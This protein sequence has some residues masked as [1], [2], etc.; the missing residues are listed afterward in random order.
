VGDRSTEAATI[1]ASGTFEKLEPET[2]PDV[3]AE[4]GATAAEL[5]RTRRRRLAL[6]GV[7]VLP[8]V[9]LALGGL[10]YSSMN[11]EPLPA[12]Y[13]A[14]GKLADD[15]RPA[16]L[17]RTGDHT[18]FV[19]IPGGTF[20][21][22]NSGFD[23]TGSSSDDDQPAHPVSLSDY[24][25]Q[26]TEVTNGEM[27]AYFRHHE[28]PHSERPARFQAAWDQIRSVG[29]DPVKY[30]AVGI[31]HQLATEYAR[32]VGG[33]LPTE[34]Q[35]EYAARSRGQPR[36][37]VWTGDEKPS[38]RNANVDS[39]GDDANVPT[40]KV[41]EF[42][43]D[44]TEQGISDLTGNVREWCRDGWSKYVAAQQPVSD[45]EGPAPASESGGPLD[46]VVRGG[47]FASFADQFRTTR[48]RRIARDDRS[49]AQLAQDRTAD[50]LG[51][52]V[53]IE[54]P[55]PSGR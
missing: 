9:A 52:R 48:P 19:R 28:I 34:A 46:F 33:E 37:F 3:S 47:S 4:T 16:V 32:W 10:I 41:G 8:A 42:N 35:W 7:L 45:P 31:S 25:L 23:P 50:D 18:R 5:V 11:A 13:H 15:G 21:M 55:R 17:V 6:A 27:D 43:K 44:Q 20:A 14:E 49:A 40:K 53:V 30:P 2:Q 1:P 29:L 12:G 24:Y 26:A 22:G 54:W 51:F 36:R 39:L 38:H